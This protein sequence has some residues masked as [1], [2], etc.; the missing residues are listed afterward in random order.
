MLTKYYEHDFSMII[1][2]TNFISQIK[3][4]HLPLSFLWWFHIHLNNVS[5]GVE[6][7]KLK[8]DTWKKML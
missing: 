5:C 4:I 8:N 3:I 1:Y 7:V 6:Q 2:K